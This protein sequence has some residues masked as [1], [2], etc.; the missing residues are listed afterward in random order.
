MTEGPQSPGEPRLNRICVFAGS[1][2]GTEDRYGR[3]ARE[4]GRLLAREGLE[5]IFGGGRWGLM[6]ELAGAALAAG[7]SAVGVIPEA[8]LQKEGRNEDLSRLEVVDSMH[9]RKARMA[10]LADGFVSLPGGLGTLE[11]TCEMLT[12]AQLGFHA[13]PCG[14]LNVG[15]YFDPLVEFLDRAVQKGFV[16][17]ED[18][19][20]LHL[21][22]TPEALLR[23]FRESRQ[24]AREKLLEREEL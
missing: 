5:V 18:R 9:E 7:G 13:K 19:E 23:R 22:S 17:A 16:D 2:S 14:L 15:G 3:A 11:E 4:L 20:L 6:G 12:W 24:P 10:E 1:R 21:A 8:L